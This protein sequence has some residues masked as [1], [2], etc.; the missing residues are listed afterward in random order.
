MLEKGRNSDSEKKVTYRRPLACGLVL[1]LLMALKPGQLNAA[2]P[3]R[4]DELPGITSGKTIAIAAAAAG[5]VVAT[6]FLLKKRNRSPEVRL[7]VDRPKI[8]A[9][10]VGKSWQGEIK[11]TNITGRPVTISRISLNGGAFTAQQSQLPLTMSPGDALTIPVSFSP[12]KAGSSKGELLIQAGGNQ[13]KSTQ[14]KVP[15]SA[16][17]M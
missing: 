3:D 17:G 16:M 6:L 14:V 7:L 2:W 15:L 13:V 12:S 8:S 10:D 1:C 9:T 11:V 4:S 5:G